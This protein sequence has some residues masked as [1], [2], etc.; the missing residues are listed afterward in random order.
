MTRAIAVPRDPAATRRS[1][2][3]SSFSHLSA[4]DPPTAPIPIWPSA[5]RKHE[6]KRGRNSSSKRRVRCSQLVAELPKQI[7]PPRDVILALDPL[8]RKPVDYAQQ[9]SSLVGLGH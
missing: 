9:P 8:R 6:A 2:P 7:L 1:G 4:S 3:S 5:F